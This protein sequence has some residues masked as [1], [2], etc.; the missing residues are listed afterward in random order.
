[1]FTTVV[2]SIKET[3]FKCLK[4][5]TMDAPVY[6]PWSWIFRLPIFDRK[7]KEEA[8]SLCGPC[9]DLII[10]IRF[11]SSKYL[12]I[13]TKLLNC[14]FHWMV[15][16]LEIPSSPF[17]MAAAPNSPC[18]SSVVLKRVWIISYFFKAKGWEDERLSKDMT[19]TVK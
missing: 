11:F 18:I 17:L 15:L 14:M 4:H 9:L 7:G 3:T 19:S 10:I 8:K 16:N 5:C 1:M 6:T 12:T 13:K 2:K